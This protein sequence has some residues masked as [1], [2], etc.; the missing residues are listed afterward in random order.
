[1]TLPTITKRWTVTLSCICAY[2]TLPHRQKQPPKHPTDQLWRG[3][4]TQAISKSPKTSR[5]VCACPAQLARHWCGF[6]GVGAYHWDD[7]KHGGHRS[8]HPVWPTWQISR[9]HLSRLWRDFFYLNQHHYLEQMA[10]LFN[11][12][13]C[14]RLQ[15]VL[16]KQGENAKNIVLSEIYKR[17]LHT[18][19]AWDSQHTKADVATLI[20][21]RV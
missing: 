6:G 19:I 10:L 17:R 3:G 14:Q 11:E 4:C 18:L 20:E 7:F 5:V 13:M 9:R 12:L 1:M 8:N 16:K 15:N 2:S 21:K